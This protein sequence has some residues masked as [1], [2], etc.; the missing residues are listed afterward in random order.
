METCVAR[1]GRA[2]AMCG[3]PATTAI[4]VVWPH[5][6][7]SDQRATVRFFPLC[8]DCNRA[9]APASAAAKLKVLGAA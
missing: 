3:E 7:A 4:M 6:G 9:L 8:G 1:Q 5:A 2:R